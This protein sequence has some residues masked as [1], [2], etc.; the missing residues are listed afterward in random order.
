MD[1]LQS[2]VVGALKDFPVGSAPNNRQELLSKAE[3]ASFLSRFQEEL[4][5]FGSV[6]EIEIIVRDYFS[7]ALELTEGE[8]LPNLTQAERILGLSNGFIQDYNKIQYI[9]ENNPNYNRLFAIV[10]QGLERSF[11]APGNSR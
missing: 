3:I 1:G 4:A 5:S 8:A 2:Q 6:D 11:D 10:A 9:K 7:K